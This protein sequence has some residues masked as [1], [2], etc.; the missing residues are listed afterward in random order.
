MEVSINQE[1]FKMETESMALEGK[2]NMKNAMA[3][4]SV[5]KLMQIRKATIRESLSNFKV[6]NTV[7]KKYLKFKMFNISMIQKQQM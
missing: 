3:A 4:T 7:L 1:E 2:H 5:A 6:W